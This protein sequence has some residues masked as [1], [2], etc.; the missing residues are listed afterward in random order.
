MWLILFAF[1]YNAIAIPVAAG[2]LAGLGLTMSPMIG[3]A[4]MSLSSFSVVTNALRLNR[5]DIRSPRRDKV[6]KKH[7]K[8]EKKTMQRTI[9]IEGMMC[10]H[11]EARV[12]ALL[13]ETDGIAAAAVSHKTGTATVTLT[14]PL[15]DDALTS[16]ITAAGYRVTAIGDQDIM[17]SKW[18]WDCE[19]IGY[20]DI[21]KNYDSLTTTARA[22]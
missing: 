3:A 2:A 5:V 13:E 7:P 4:A 12:K 1:L 15:T 18:R 6:I 8:K 21:S 19:Q 10:P 16:L 20:S 22:L 9:H 17:I 11:C 14:S